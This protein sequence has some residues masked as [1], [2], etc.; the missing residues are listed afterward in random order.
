MCVCVGVF[1][2]YRYLSVGRRVCVSVLFFVIFFFKFPSIV[3]SPAENVVNIIKPRPPGCIPIARTLEAA[4]HLLLLLL[5]KYIYTNT[6][7]NMFYLPGI[8]VR[9]VKID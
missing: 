3:V 1:V 9:G 7:Y 4:G 5:Y 2:K 6:S 8:C